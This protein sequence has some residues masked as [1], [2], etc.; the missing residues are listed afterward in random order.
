MVLAL[1]CFD[2]KIYNKC[3]SIKIENVI[4]ILNY[5]ELDINKVIFTLCYVI[6][7][8]FHLVNCNDFVCDT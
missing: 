7:C 5:H 8:N 1:K 3:T 6:F 2:E 4:D